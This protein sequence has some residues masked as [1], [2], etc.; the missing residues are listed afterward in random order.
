M[1]AHSIHALLLIMIAED[2]ETPSR[3]RVVADVDAVDCI[4]HAFNL[5]YPRCPRV[6]G[7]FGFSFVGQFWG[8]MQGLIEGL[9]KGVLIAGDVYIL[10]IVPKA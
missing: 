4:E 6:L 8:F 9:E 7:S 3:L 2:Q 1:D 10:R 5:I